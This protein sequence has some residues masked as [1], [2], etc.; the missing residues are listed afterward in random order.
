MTDNFKEEIIKECE[1]QSESCLY[2]STSLYCW[3]R[4]M[5]RWNRVLVVAPIILGGIGSWSILERYSAHPVIVWIAAICSL[6]AGLLPTIFKTLGLDGHIGYVSDQAAG[7]KNL[8]DR[9]RQLSKFALHKTYEDVKS[10]FDNLMQK[11]EELRGKSITAPERFFTAAQK[12]IKA[13]DYSFD[14]DE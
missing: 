11:M 10:E 7:Y 12:K 8:Q 14:S 13:G 6:L 5:R 4:S 2:T 1:R 9:F 3:L